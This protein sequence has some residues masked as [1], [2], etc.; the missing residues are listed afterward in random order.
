MLVKICGRPINYTNPP[1]KIALFLG[2]QSLRTR[3][4]L[5]MTRVL[6][7]GVTIQYYQSTIMTYFL[8]SHD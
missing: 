7:K 5:Y 3:L 4:W 1:K 6:N 8:L 2:C